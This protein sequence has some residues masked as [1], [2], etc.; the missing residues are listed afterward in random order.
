M[1]GKSLERMKQEWYWKA[2]QEENGRLQAQREF[3]ARP[4]RHKPLL[5]GLYDY[6]VT[7]IQEIDPVDILAVGGLSLVIQPVILASEQFTA[8][9]QKN[10]PFGVWGFLNPVQ[11]V[12][13][14]E[15]IAGK[16]I[17]GQLEG[18]S[19]P[20]LTKILLSWVLAIAISA[21]IIKS[22]GG[23]NG[24]LDKINIGNLLTGLLLLK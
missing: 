16:G 2:K 4:A 22:V 20:D 21:I 1:G 11:A 17:L 18:V 24:A 13:N 19:K 9:L 8:F 5:D 10:A 7:K 12:I 3:N 14:I 15:T 23:V 6:I